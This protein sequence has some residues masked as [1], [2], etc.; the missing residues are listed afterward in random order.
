[1]V[2]ETPLNILTLR[3][4]LK[5]ARIS[6]SREVQ[7]MLFLLSLACGFPPPE[8]RTDCRM[9]LRHWNAQCNTSYFTDHFARQCNTLTTFRSYR[10]VFYRIQTKGAQCAEE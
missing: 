5:A 4:P 2:G 10:R 7:A 3:D 6:A 8:L 1:M 9:M